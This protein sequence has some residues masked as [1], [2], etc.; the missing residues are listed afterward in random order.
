[1]VS[2]PEVKNRGLTPFRIDS[3]PQAF[4]IHELVLADLLATVATKSGLRQESL[5][6]EDGM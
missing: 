5:G 2:C 6:K 3:K 1:M 4:E